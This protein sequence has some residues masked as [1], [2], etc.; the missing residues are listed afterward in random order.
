LQNNTARFIYNPVFKNLYTKRDLQGLQQLHQA[1]EGGNGNGGPGDNNQDDKL[2]WTTHHITI[3]LPGQT[4]GVLV[5]QKGANKRPEDLLWRL[6]R[7]M[8]PMQH[9]LNRQVRFI[10]SSSPCQRTGGC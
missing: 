1:K 6:H 8:S 3:A 5:G 7:S 10:L 4:T 9:M 2:D